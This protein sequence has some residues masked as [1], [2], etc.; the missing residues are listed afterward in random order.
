MHKTQGELFE[1]IGKLGW[2]FEHPGYWLKEIEPTNLLV[3]SDEL[4]CFYDS[5][6]KIG[7]EAKRTY[8]T[9]E[10]RCNLFLSLKLGKEVNLC[11]D[12]LH[13]P[14]GTYWGELWEN[15]DGSR[16][17]NNITGKSRIDI[18]ISWFDHCDD[19]HAELRE[20]TML[21]HEFIM[22]THNK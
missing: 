10:A 1:E 13:H 22:N 18:D 15:P 5:I 11:I 21:I 16:L 6:E 9:K 8:T 4:V 12:Y 14:I 17:S 19:E 20:L 2:T 7:N 3:V